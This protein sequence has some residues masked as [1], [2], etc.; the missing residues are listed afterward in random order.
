MR[1]RYLLVFLFTLLLSWDAEA[2]CINKG[3]VQDCMFVL[4]WDWTGDPTQADGFSAQRQQ[5]D[6]SWLT[7]LPNIPISARQDD[8][9]IF[10]DPGGVQQCYRLFAFNSTGMSDP[11]N[12][13]CATSPIINVVTMKTAAIVT[14]SHRATD[15]SSIIAVLVNANTVIGAGGLELTYPPGFTL[16][17]SRRASNTSSVIA[18]LVNKSTNVLINP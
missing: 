13:A 11:S 9:T 10:N 8:E 5:V 12:V 7:V 16:T 1:L 18:L 6:G 2:A 3:T 17:V 4:S 15:T 14:T